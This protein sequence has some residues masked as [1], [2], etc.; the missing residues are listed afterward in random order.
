MGKNDKPAAVRKAAY[1]AAKTLRKVQKKVGLTE[2][3][4]A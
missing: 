4:R 2:R 3:I 1:Y